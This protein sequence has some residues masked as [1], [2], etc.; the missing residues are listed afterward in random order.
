MAE[1]PLPTIAL[2]TDHAGFPY[3]EAVRAFLE[4]EGYPVKDCGAHSTEPCDYP[5]F[6][7]P[8][9][10]AVA[11]GEAALAVVFGGSGNGEAMAANKVR[12]IRCAVCWSLYTA[13]KARQHNDANCISI[14][15]RTISQE[16]AVEIV[17]TWLGSS[18]EGGRHGARIAKIAAYEAGEENT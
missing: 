14:G 5:D 9:A 3:K 1:T 4:G 16:L 2:G 13:E 6:V 15:S 8:A 11:R 10:E 7:I 18:F 12:G 17:A